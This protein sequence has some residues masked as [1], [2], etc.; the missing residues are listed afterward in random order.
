MPGFL[1]FELPRLAARGGLTNVAYGLYRVPD[2]PPTRFDQFAEVCY[3]S[4]RV[5]TCMGNRCCRPRPQGR[6]LG[7]LHD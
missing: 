7:S 1:R 3:K 4:A 6:S 5:R 2:I